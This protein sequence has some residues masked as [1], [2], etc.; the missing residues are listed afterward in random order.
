[1]KQ[2]ETP[3]SL[4]S[5]NSSFRK[6]GEIDLS[7][8][9]HNLSLLNDDLLHKTRLM[10]RLTVPATFQRTAFLS[11]DYCTTT[12]PLQGL[13]SL[14]L[15]G[16][17][18]TWNPVGSTEQVRIGSFLKK[19]NSSDTVDNVTVSFLALLEVPATALASNTIIRFILHCS[20]P[21]LCRL[22]HTDEITVA[23]EN[24]EDVSILSSE[25]AYSRNSSA[26][27]EFPITYTPLCEFV[28]TLKAVMDATATQH[29]LTV[30]AS[31]ENTCT[32]LETDNEKVAQDVEELLGGNR[33]A[34]QLSIQT[35][36]MVNTTVAP[37][38][39]NDGKN[40]EHQKMGNITR[41]FQYDSE[42]GTGGLVVEDLRECVFA[43][44][45]PRQV[46]ELLA[47]ER[48]SQYHQARIDLNA[49]LSQKKTK[50]DSGF[51]GTLL[52]QIQVRIP[53]FYS[54]F[55]I[56]NNVVVFIG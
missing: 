56:L 49:F 43:N 27:V 7:R 29:S 46:L 9:D 31:E 1:M 39:N 15:L 38:K 16:R 6:M 12:V 19:D 54:L 25:E 33:E 34:A 36:L 21:A 13:H 10:I 28:T 11:L 20:N 14:R 30:T 18:A 48:Q 24:M 5:P 17:S 26:E 55:S 2:S 42:D 53:S 52:A 40:R 37:S 4:C 51:Y 41:F 3:T 22:T 44:S 45:I 35:V 47:S 8:R 23:M 50:T 32:I